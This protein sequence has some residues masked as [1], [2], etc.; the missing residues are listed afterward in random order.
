MRCVNGWSGHSRKSFINR[1]SALDRATLPALPEALKELLSDWRR[2]ACAQSGGE[3]FRELAELADFPARPFPTMPRRSK[4]GPSRLSMYLANMLLTEAG[5]FL[6]AGRMFAM[7]FPADKKREKAQFLEQIAAL[8][9]CFWL[10]IRA[11]FRP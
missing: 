3:L 1:Y 4:R 5:S 2:F 11:G 9:S 10:G 8:T 6:Q 7:D